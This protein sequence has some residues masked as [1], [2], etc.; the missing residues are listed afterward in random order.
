MRRVSLFAC[1]LV[2]ACTHNPVPEDYKGPLARIK[3]SA[4]VTSGINGDF[5]FVERVNG[6][7]IANSRAASNKASQGMGFGGKL[8]LLERDVPAR[9]ATYTVVGRTN[10]FPPIKAMFSTEYE[11][12]G[13]I[14]VSPVPNGTYVV[15]GQLSAD[16]SAVWIESVDTGELLGKKIEIKGSAKLNILEK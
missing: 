1:L 2:G 5:F 10:H 6:D 11:V 13:D 15:K 3:D 7:K 12:R 16:Y 4:N 8:I 9:A 14:R